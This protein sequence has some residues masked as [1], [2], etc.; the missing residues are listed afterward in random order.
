M[1]AR[2]IPFP[3]RRPVSDADRVEAAKAK[4]EAALAFDQNPS[5][6]NR[7]RLIDAHRRLAETRHGGMP[8]L[9]D[10][11]MAAFLR[12]MTLSEQEPA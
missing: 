5:P 2:I 4:C 10:R 7:E 9:I 3:H 6:E 11:D 1:T 8:A 12:M